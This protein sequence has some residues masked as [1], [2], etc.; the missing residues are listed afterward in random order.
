MTR[1]IAWFLKNPNQ[2]KMHSIPHKSN[3]PSCE[4]SLRYFY[5]STYLHRHL[6]CSEI[7]KLLLEAAGACAVSVNEGDFE[8][9]ERLSVD[10]VPS[11][12]Q[13]LYLFPTVYHGFWLNQIFW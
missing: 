6:A 1:Y 13:T 7:H 5:I 2:I 11:P 8:G 4:G 12:E 3:I 9:E 10:L